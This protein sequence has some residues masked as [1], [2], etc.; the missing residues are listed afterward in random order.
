MLNKY[1]VYGL[2]ALILVVVSIGTFGF[3]GQTANLGAEGDTNMTN[4]VLSG[5]LNFDSGTDGLGGIICGTKTGWD[6]LVLTSL[7]NTSST[8][9]TTVTVTGATV[10]AATTCIASNNGTSTVGTTA[11]CQITSAGVATYSLTTSGEVDYGGL[12]LKACAVTTQ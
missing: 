7:T 2:L 8:A 5:E 6:P 1:V 11:S 12:D 3:G 9:T 10:S 4:L